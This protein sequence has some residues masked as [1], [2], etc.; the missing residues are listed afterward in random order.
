MTNL[1]MGAGGAGQIIYKFTNETDIS[2]DAM[3][4]M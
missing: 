1:E 4:C 2:Y 3:Q